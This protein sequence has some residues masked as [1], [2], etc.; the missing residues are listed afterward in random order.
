LNSTPLGEVIQE[1]QL[2][3]HRNRAGLRIGD[4][5]RIDLVRYVAW[6]VRERHKPKAAKPNHVP[7]DS[8]MPANAE[9][10]AALVAESGGSERLGANQ[11]STIAAMLSSRTFAEAAERIGVGRATIY[12]WL[13]NPVFRSAFRRAKRELTEAA[14]AKIHAAAGE[15]VDVL[16]NVARSGRRDS[17][18]VRAATTILDHAYRGL[19]DAELLHGPAGA[20]ARARSTPRTS[21]SCSPLAAADRRL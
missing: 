5:R 3:N 18:R 11:Q 8:A 19:Q 16:V 4:S 2:K 1:H 7:D 17:D 12:R 6:L 9:S 20:G 21:S 10:A 15:V 14:V 13:L